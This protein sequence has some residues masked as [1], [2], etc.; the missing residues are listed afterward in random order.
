MR[1]TVIPPQ[2]VS[3]HVILK[4]PSSE[5]ELVPMHL[6]LISVSEKFVTH[7]VYFAP[8]INFFAEMLFVPRLI[9]VGS[10]VR[11]RAATKCTQIFFQ[12]L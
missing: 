12:V 6:S 4:N 10:D 7:L 1:P 9:I 5:F 2:M 3:K 8:T 11:M